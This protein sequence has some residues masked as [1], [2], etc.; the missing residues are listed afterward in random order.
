M[1][2][3]GTLTVCRILPRTQRMIFTT[4]W[5][6]LVP[7]LFA[8]LHR[9]THHHI[10]RSMFLFFAC[11]IPSA[12][13]R[14]AFCTRSEATNGSRH[15]TGAH[16]MPR[17]FGSLTKYATWIFCF[18]GIR[19]CMR[20]VYLSPVTTTTV[21]D[22]LCALFGGNA[23]VFISTQRARRG[24][25]PPHAATRLTKQKQKQNKKQNKTHDTVRN[26]FTWGCRG[27]EGKD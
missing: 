24:G 2:A 12:S 9:F 5:P 25:H 8:R 10:F 3:N 20:N 27:Y 19:L 1:R 16:P 22:R 17:P 18:V 15:N 4:P 6:I 11:C 26:K 21:E 14:V 23:A 7:V 13:L